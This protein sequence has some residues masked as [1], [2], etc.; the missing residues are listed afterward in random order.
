MIIAINQDIM[1]KV[2][3]TTIMVVDIINPNIT[4]VIGVHGENGMII[5]DTTIVHIEKVVITDK[6]EVSILNLKPK[7]G[8]L[9]SLLE[10]N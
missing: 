4:E 8:A 9:F 10:D 6:M 3:D 1:V 2:T 5:E 7:M